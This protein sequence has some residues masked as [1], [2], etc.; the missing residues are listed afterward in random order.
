MFA[1]QEQEEGDAGAVGFGLII[2][3][4]V[5]QVV[6]LPDFDLCYTNWRML[7]LD[8]D[9]KGSDR[10]HSYYQMAQLQEGAAQSF[11]FLS[12]SRFTRH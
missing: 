6:F 4:F 10:A 9:Q 7:P 12:E 1:G 5:R 8:L 2:T 11:T 3:V